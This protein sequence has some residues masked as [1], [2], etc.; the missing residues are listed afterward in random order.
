MIFTILKF[1]HAVSGTIA[2]GA[3]AWMLFGFLEGK[4]YK[5]RVAVFFEFTVVASASGLLFP[6]H[7]FLPAHWAAMSAVYV[8]GVAVLAWRRYRL[9]GIW[10]LLFALS[11]MLVLCLDI[12]V[13]LA[14]I[15][16]M[17]IPA[18]PKRL[19]LAMELMVLLL[20][21]GLSLLT[22]RKHRESQAGPMV[23]PQVNGCN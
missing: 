8:S 15:F 6:F 18:Q 3:G 21:G 11:T 17:L 14:H 9:A 1:V 2:I 19:F 12:F 23:R 7:H 13:V 20:F 4:L 10:A 5:K 22:V 16:E